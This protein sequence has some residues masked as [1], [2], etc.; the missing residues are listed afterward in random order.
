MDEQKHQ[1]AL[2]ED[3]KAYKKLDKI[4]NSTEFDDFFKMQITTVTQ[5]MLSCFTGSKPLSYEEYLAVRGE[6]I[7]YLYPI[8][9]IRG[10]KVMAKQ[11]QD[12]LDAYYN[13]KVDI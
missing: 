10:A 8:Q 13:Q 1:E 2:N 9:Q 4:N 5:K 11:L 12:Q 7:A 6:I 3:L